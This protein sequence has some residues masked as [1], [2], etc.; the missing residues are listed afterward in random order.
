MRIAL[1]T[2]DGLWEVSEIT[3]DGGGARRAA[4]AGRRVTH[5]AQRGDLRMAVVPR[6]GAYLG[7]Q[8][9]F[10]GDARSCAIGADHS[11]WVGVEPAMI[12]CSDDRGDSWR[13]CDAI[14]ALPTRASW[15]FPPPPH[16]P[17][18]LSI[19]FL[20]GDPHGVVAG[21]EVGGALISRDGGR[22]WREINEGLYVDVHSLRPDPSRPGALYAVTGRGFYASEDGGES[23]ER[24]MTGVENGYTIGLHV[25]PSRAGEI[26]ISA[27]DRPPGLNGRLYHTLDAGRSW[28]ELAGEGLPAECKRAPVPF[29]AGG[30]AWVATDQG[31]LL[32]A[33]DPRKSWELVESL[34]IPIH[35][36]AAD[37]G[38][39]SVMH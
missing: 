18:V 13:R 31:K 23:W 28:Q 7:E 17:H 4:L 32:H 15:T 11:L 2:A 21:V 24:R 8:R 5:V 25:H 16:Q 39:S 38:P 27:G 33:E 10:T 14:D 29:F 6:E 3:N 19:D 34:P 22:S 37:G 9:V 30:M 36:V 1:G 26:L 20:P 35:A 12:F